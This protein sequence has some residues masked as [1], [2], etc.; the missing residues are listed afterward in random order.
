MA[1]DEHPLASIEDAP[2]DGPDAVPRDDLVGAEVGVLVE[3]VLVFASAAT[4]NVEEDASCF[5]AGTECFSSREIEK[6]DAFQ[7][8]EK[9]FSNELR[10]TTTEAGV[11]IN[12]LFV[13]DERRVASRLVGGECSVVAVDEIAGFDLESSVLQHVGGEMSLH[14]VG[15][16]VELC[17]E[18]SGDASSKAGE[19]GS[20][21]GDLAT[22]VEERDVWVFPGEEPASW[23]FVGHP[24]VHGKSTL[25]IV[26]V[27]NHRQGLLFQRTA[28]QGR[29]GMLSRRDGACEVTT[30]ALADPA[31]EGRSR[32]RFLQAV[33]RV[34]PCVNGADACGQALSVTLI[35][36]AGSIRNKEIRTGE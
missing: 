30:Y 8:A 36:D 31:P 12:E 10:G 3:A 23:S 26:R 24:S 25:E 11:A 6:N 32:S 28:S 5:A 1:L 13:L 9:G 22:R 34:E 15:G 27:A 2:D 7:L 4:V 21:E 17:S 20:R 18:V 19:A 14:D 29:I 35:E 16:T 33:D